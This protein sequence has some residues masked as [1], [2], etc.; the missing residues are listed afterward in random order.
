VAERFARG[1]LTPGGTFSQH[2]TEGVDVGLVVVPSP[3]RDPRDAE[4][5]R[6]DARIRAETE[7][8]R[9]RLVGQE[10]VV[11]G[12]GYGFSLS[13]LKA[14]FSGRAAAQRVLACY[15]SLRG[16]CLEGAVR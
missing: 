13:L 10:D 7:D 1:V 9:R 11:R 6:Y 4:S 5:E 3:P 2:R 15:G 8:R 16:I 12:P 14:T